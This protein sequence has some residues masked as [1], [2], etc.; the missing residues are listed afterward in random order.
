MRRNPLIQRTRI[1]FLIQRRCAI[2]LLVPIFLG[3]WSAR[4]LSIPPF[5]FLL[6][7]LLSRSHLFLPHS[8]FSLPLPLSF[9]IY[10]S[11]SSPSFP[12]LPWTTLTIWT[13]CPRIPESPVEIPGM[14]RIPPR[15]K[16]GCV[17]TPSTS[18]PPR[19]T[20]RAVRS[21]RPM[22]IPPRILEPLPRLHGG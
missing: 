22:P 17:S 14:S 4:C 3:Y 11:P 13:L 6:L 5:I 10:H 18:T 1:R 12:H 20:L 15:T 21:A 19:A 8:S 2:F 7:L 16:S 9:S